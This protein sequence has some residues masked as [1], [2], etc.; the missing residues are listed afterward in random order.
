M[1]DLDG[2]MMA[3]AL[4][5][6]RKGDP[7]PNPHVGCVIVD[8]EQVIGEGFHESAGMDHAEMSALRQA[9]DAARGK[10]MYVTMEP[11]NH[12]GRTAPC[13]DAI[14]AAEISKVVIA[15]R[16]PNPGVPGQG[17]ERLREAGVEV[18]VGV[19]EKEASTVIRP[20]KKYVTT[21]TAYLALKLAVSL[22]GRIATRT[23]ASKWITCQ[24][25]RARVHT[26]RHEHDAVLVGI[27]TVMTDDPRL[28]V[29]DVPGRNP[30]RVVLD[31][32]LRLPMNSQLVSSAA[33]VPTCVVTTADASRAVAENLESA[34]LSV[35]RVPATAEGRCDMRIALQ[36]LAAREVVTVL[37]EGGAELGGSLLASGLADELHVFVAPVLLGPRGRAAAVDW[38][39]PETPAEAPRIE[40][41]QWELCGTD[42]YVSGRVVY[43]KV[44]AK[45]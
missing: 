16:D 29:R 7:S 18:V 45:K 26:L 1:A 41:P 9:G 15:C 2:R 32:T 30:I 44:Y 31:S 13:V 37:C 40:S 23:G 38:A 3:R 5:L 4:E 10:C 12:E 28:T 43:A 22:D 36:E 14:L 6:A 33:E 39:G 21:Q 24:E 11:C 25:S 27:N 34:G 8:G 20:W 42:A 19:L 35:I 17:V